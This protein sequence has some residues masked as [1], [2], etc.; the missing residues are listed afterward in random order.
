MSD[1]LGQITKG[2]DGKSK[3]S[4]LNLFDKYRGK[5]IEAIRTSV[6]PRHG[7]QSLGKVAAARRMPPP[8]NLP[9]LKSENKGNNPN[10]IL[11]P[12]DGT[13]WANKQELPDQKSSNVTTAQPPESQLPQASQKS[14]STFQT[15]TQQSSQEIIHL[16]PGGPRSWAQL[17]GRPVGPGGGSRVSNRPLSFSPE[18]FP[19]LKAAGEQDKAGKEKS[20]FDPSYGPGPSLRPQNVTS[21]REGGGRSAIGISPTSPTASPTEPGIKT[22]TAT[23][24][25]APSSAPISDPKEP[26]LRPAQ[27]TRKGA[28]QFAG[29]VYHPPTYHDMLPAFMCSQPSNSTG[30]S[31]RASFPL[32]SQA[33]LEPRVPFR[34]YHMNDQDGKDRLPGARA[35]RVV[36]PPAPVQLEQAPR[37]TIIHAEDLKELDELDNDTEDGWAGLQEEVD[38]AEKLKFSED[39]ED[40][41]AL[42][43]GR[44]KWNGWDCRGL[45]VPPRSAEIQARLGPEA[46]VFSDSRLVSENRLN[47]DTRLASDARHSQDV[48]LS[49]ASRLVTIGRLSSDARLRSDARLGSEGRLRSDARLGSEGRLRSDARLG[50]EGRL[51]QDARLGSEGRLGQDARLGSEGRLGQ[52]ARLGSEGRLGQDARLGSEGRLGQDARL[53]SEGRLGQDARLG[54]EGRLGQDARLGSEGRLGQD[55]R[56][57]TEGRLGQDARLGT[58]GRLGQDAR[59]GTEG[60]LGQDARLGTEGRL[61]QDARLGSEGR[62]GQDARLGSEGRLGQDA[63]LGSEG[64]LG[65]DARLGSEGRLGQ[66]ARLGSEGRLGQDARLGS[67]GRLGQDARLGSEGRLGQDARLGSEGRLGQDARLGSEGRLGQDARLG[68]EGRLGQDARLGSEGRLGQ[69]A[70]LGSEG[71]LGQDARLGSEG[72]LGQDARIVSESRLG[73]DAQIVSENRLGQDGRLAAEGR[74]GQDGRLAAEGSLGQDARLAA[75]PHLCQDLRLSSEVRL[76]QDTLL[77]SEAR[78]NQDVRYISDARLCS[79]ARVASDFHLAP[80]A[81]LLSDARLS[82]NGRLALDSRLVSDVQL[83]SDGRLCTDARVFSDVRLSPEARLAP[84]PRLVSDARLDPD[85]HL[86]PETR[87][88]SEDCLATEARGVPD[89]CL[90]PDTLLDQDV[91][92]TA[93]T[94]LV[95][96]AHLCSNA[97]LASDSLLGSDPR[98]VPDTRPGHDVRLLSEEGRNWANSTTLP[99][100]QRKN[101]EPT[102]QTARKPTSW[103][104]PTETQ[105]APPASFLRQQSAEE[106]DDKLPVRQKFVP[107]EISE[108]VERARR[109]REEEER[110]ARDERLAACAAKLKQLDQKSKLAQKSVDAPKQVDNKENEDPRSPVFEKSSPPSNDRSH[111]KGEVGVPQGAREEVRRTAVTPEFPA[112]ETAPVYLEEQPAE[113]QAEEVSTSED[114]DE[115]LPEPTSPVQEFSK[116]Q[117][118]L[119]PRFQRQQQQ[120]QLYK[121]QHWQQQQQQQQAYAPPSHSHQRNF[122]P[123]HPQMLGFDPRWMMMPPYMDPRM[124]QG[125]SPVDFYPSAIHPS[126]TMKQMAQQDSMNGPSGC[127]SDHC[128][129]DESCQPSMQQERR[130]PSTELPQSWSQESYSPIQNKGYT[131]G[132]HRQAEAIGVDGVHSRN[133]SAYATSVERSEGIHAQRDQFEERGEEYSTTSNYD[134]KPQVHYSCCISPRKDQEMLFEP[135]EMLPGQCDCRARQGNFK[136]SP[137]SDSDF[138]QGDK[139]HYNGWDIPQCPKSSDTSS[140]VEEESCKDDH[141]THPV[142]WK[143][144]FDELPTGDWGSEASRSTNCQ[145]QM[146]RTRRSGPNKKPILKDLKVEETKELVK[147][148]PDAEEHAQTT[149]EKV[150]NSSTI[151]NEASIYPDSSPTPDGSL[152]EDKTCGY[153]SYTRESEKPYEDKSARLCESKFPEAKYP[154][155]IK[156]SNWIFIDEEQAFGDRGQVRGRSRAFK[157]FTIRGGRG[158]GTYSST[159]NAR[160]RGYREFIQI[161]AFTRGRPM[162]RRVLN[163]TPSEGSE[164]EELPKR[165]RERGY[166]NGNE[167]VLPEREGNTLQRGDLRDSWRSN[168]IYSEPSSLDSRLRTQ[169]V[170]GRSLPPRLTGQR[171][172][173]SKES[174][175]WRGKSNRW[176]GD[177]PPSD[178]FGYRGPSENDYARNPNRFSDS[179]SAQVYDGYQDGGCIFNQDDYDTEGMDNRASRRRRAPR[180]DKP[181]RFRRLQQEKDP[182]GQLTRTVGANVVQTQWSGQSML[183]PSDRNGPPVT[184]SPE[185]TNHNCS[186]QAIEEWETASESSDFS[187]RREGPPE[188]DGSLSSGSLG[189]KREMSKRSF[190]SQRPLTDRQS[191]KVDT[192]GYVETLGKSSGNSAQNDP[193]GS[194]IKTESRSPV[195]ETFSALSRLDSGSNHSLYS[196]ERSTHSSA[197]SPDTPG[198]KHDKEPKSSTQKTSET[199]VQYDGSYSNSVLENRL[200]CSGEESDAHAVVPEAFIEALTKKQRRLLEEEQRRKKEQAVQAPAKGR[201]LASRM[202]PRFAKKQNGICLDQGDVSVSGSSLGTE[203]WETSKQA[204]SS[205]SCSDSWSKPGNAF[206]SSESNS[207]E[208]SD[209]SIPQSSSSGTATNSVKMQDTLAGLS[210]SIP[211]LR[212]EH[213][214]QQGMSLNPMSFPTAELTLKM[215]SARKAWE[216]SPSLP[217]QNSPGGPSS[218][219]QA[220]SSVGA[221]NGV[222][223]SSFGGVSMPPM[224][225]ASVAPSASIPGNHITPLYLDGHVFASQPR[226]VQQTI[227]QQQGYQQAAAQQI[228]ISLHTSLQAPGQMG[229]R[230][231]LPVSQSQDMYGS[232]QQFRSQVY[233]HPSLSQPNTMVLT[234][235]TA[236]KPSYSAFPPMQPMEMVKSQSGSPYQPMNGSQPLVYD[237]QM[238]QASQMMDSQLSQLPMPRYNSG[239]QPLLLQQSIQLP[240]GQ[241]LSVGAPRRIMPPG[242]QPSV[243]TGSRESQLEMKGFHF[244]DCKQN[245]SSSGPVQ[246]SHSYRPSSASPS[247][248]PPGS[249]PATSMSSVHGHYSQQVKRAD[250]IKNGSGSG[251]L[252]EPPSG[253]QLKPTRTGAIKPQA[254]KVEESKA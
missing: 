27:P 89:A 39:E 194:P 75:E 133:E 192:T 12:K 254:T 187:E 244:T 245:V 86:A 40:E 175:N 221:S 78:H 25:G 172:F 220:P 58:E 237:G 197:D 251:K 120:E 4:S 241:S 216:N 64:R 104:A 150:E 162:R 167:G 82:P 8:A 246:A 188:V 100:S 33:R 98:L 207:T 80:D 193:S 66:D 9:S 163:E 57:G 94:R 178:A 190:S 203:I 56:L 24:D 224:T 22:T 128:R 83:A 110:R 92:L 105:K 55:A 29:N 116:Y 171:G 183:S 6:I 88:V 26:S 212:R 152:L 170:F 90:A 157:E 79:D 199:L 49:S 47:T 154:P 142:S 144:M 217:E 72:R 117:K 101:Q 226:L 30:T 158:K 52:D 131:L 227:P 62:L 219:I 239:Q 137:L 67:E 130:P 109:R 145:E 96:D 113:P 135:Q 164:Y 125:R 48:R 70:R 60:R 73:Q 168:K 17:N 85:A 23:G 213:H 136:G 166:D 84:D 28:S 3:Y 32:P 233:M 214:L 118:S 51:G 127:R 102:S 208:D 35:T 174:L 43:E 31:E 65:Q 159:R 93:D 53:G 13:G 7:L 108:A 121:M 45:Q 218:G 99:P 2:K 44:L 204:L 139:A 141:T 122:Y 247:G 232:M 253:N 140:S 236:L 240:Q 1:R 176:Q 225:V 134:L 129:P 14:A 74:L 184:R 161:N 206:T 146:G 95:T 119:P 132:Q 77:S 228:P 71:R 229:L 250:E 238:S 16:V 223:Y 180:Q 202:P 91:Q 181:P 41:E 87:P 231:G 112:Q 124:A 76:N 209:F 189:E 19:T 42:K 34:Q 5:S 148:K 106:K 11:V 185:L 196:M 160:G 177:G 151:G 37:A 165:R 147:I 15:P 249:G 46:P 126:G 21:W 111:V 103:P 179:F 156:R 10:I 252:Q 138:I 248:K 149:K 143:E 191:R 186:D 54:S 205:Q 68:S 63:R 123:P 69:D 107:S 235:G 211:I 38:Y 20:V 97:Q 50:S 210:Q 230:G 222:N 155:P 115:E 173:E 243:L 198:K 61:G 200:T 18:E 242:S 182:V 36:R 153:S 201:V 234:G 215:E 81:H 59:L 114:D 169:R 195:D